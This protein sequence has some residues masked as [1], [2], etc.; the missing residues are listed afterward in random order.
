MLDDKLQ[1]AAPGVIGELYATGVGLAYGYAGQP[2]QTALSFLP[3]PYGTAGS[4]MYRTGDLGRRNEDGTLDVLGRADDQVKIRGFRV[5]P[6]EVAAALRRHPSV[7]DCAVIA[8]EPAPGET[9]LAAYLTA[10]G[11]A[12]GYREIRRHLAGEVPDHM[13]PS[14]VTVLGALPLTR[15]GKLD[16]AALPAP[17]GRPGQ[18][19]LADVDDALMRDIA[20][21]WCEVLGVEQVGPADD[22]F[23]LGGHSLTALR[24]LYALRAKL[25]IDI[26][27]RDLLDA[28]DLAAFTAGVREL[29]ER[30]APAARPAIPL[31]GR[32][33]TR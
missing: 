2:G 6:G 21:L 20:R 8:Y 32:R 29:L 3:N 27:L 31:T 25:G 7:G 11:V 14:S 10:R 19:G 9:A 28:A 16:R 26:P 17:A 22:F 24:T 30:G 13:I 15:N 23:R 5:E 1:P 12:P 33:G 4:R 18:A